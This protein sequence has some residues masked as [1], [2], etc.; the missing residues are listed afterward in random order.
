MR[1]VENEKLKG[2]IS[3]KCGEDV[4]V[5]VQVVLRGRISLRQWVLDC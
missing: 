2:V 5:D 1:V 3:C 4:R